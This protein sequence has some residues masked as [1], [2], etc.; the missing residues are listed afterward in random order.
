MAK[1]PKYIKVRWET[2]NPFT[3]RI[4]VKSW[5]MPILIYQV[6]KKRFQ[7]KWWQW[8]FYPYFCFRVMKNGGDN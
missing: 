4:T 5:G 7:I 2:H 1:L 3:A 8:I 6:L